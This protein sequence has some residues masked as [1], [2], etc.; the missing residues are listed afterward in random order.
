MPNYTVVG[1]DI[2]TMKITF[3]IK[4]FFKLTSKPREAVYWQLLFVSMLIRIPIH[5]V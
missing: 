5:S 2:N 4:F 1:V 3:L